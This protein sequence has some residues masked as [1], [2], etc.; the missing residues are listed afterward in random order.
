MS[1]LLHRLGGFAARR[2]LWVIGA[3]VVIAVGLILI[4][5]SAGRPE[6]DNVDLPGTGS[7]NATNLLENKLPQQANGS[8]PIVL[9]S[10]TSLAEGKNAQTVNAVV[11]SLSKN[12]YV[13]QVLS[14][15]SPQGAGAI[16]KDGKIAYVS[17]A[18][19]PS[20]GDITDDQANSVLDAA[21]KP[22]AGTGIAVSAGGYLG[23][24][25]SSPSTR[26]SEI[27][28]VIAALVIM[29][30][31]FRLLVAM[32]LPVT[33]A[34]V[35]LASG[36]AIVGLAGHLF[37]VP[38]IAPTLATMLGLAVGT[39]YSLFIISRHL[40]LLDE[41]AEPNDSIARSISSSGSAVIFAAVMVIIALL[42]LYFSGIPLVRSLGYTTAIVVATAAVAA[43]TL[44][45]AI[46]G[47]L[48]RRIQVLP[49]V[50][51][52]D[53]GTKK[54]S[55]GW[56]G[57]S[58][59]I[60]NHPL[61]SSVAGIAVLV[62][63]AIPALDLYLGAPDYGLLPTDTTE[64]QAYDAITKGFGV[65][66]NGP[67]LI[68]VDV[69][70]KPLTSNPQQVSQLQQ[71]QAQIQ[72]EEAVSGP[73]PQ[74]QSQQQQVSEE[75]QI[76]STPAGD[77]RLVNLEQQISKQDNVQSVSP[78]QTD[79]GGT[80]A[81]FSTTPK[82]SPSDRKTQDLIDHLRDSTIPDTTNGQGMTAYVGGT[83]ASYIDL[84]IKIGDKLL[85]VIAIVVLLSILFLTMAFRTLTIPLVS[86]LINLLAVA[87][88]YGVLT[89]V[90]EKGFGLSL[91]GVDHE[92][93]VVSYVPLMMFAILFGLSMDYQV[94][95]VSRI[96]ERHGGG[97]DN[98]ESVRAG[99]VNAGKPILAAATIMF[100]V[101]FSFVIN[102]NP[103]VKQFGVGLAVSVAIDALVV[104]LIMP[105][106]L[107]LIGERNWF[108]PRWLD[109]I[110]PNLQVE[111]D[112]KM[113]SETPP[114]Q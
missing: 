60:K 102:G 26:A 113:K 55:K 5:N 20:S 77:Q 88:S 92:M 66:T 59:A 114:S 14:P 48:G 1:A 65:G 70:G 56:D 7:Q 39:D 25:L 80:A 32:P 93:P 16:T 105:G 54:Q 40:R 38:S 97:A 79:K 71:Q 73:T 82:T 81:V 34:I 41:G 43:I 83:T 61:I 2:A 108:M 85:L 11:A 96:E 57:W 106:L 101:F 49:L 50:R 68:A 91:L 104:L 36:L 99:L 28:A 24:Q 51:K 107:E 110:L 109:R 75:L 35:A 29:L 10:S 78:A 18:L 72:Q 74:L 6:S 33:T 47:L 42:C 103:I 52:L 84:A 94:F 4:A 3:W 46:L 58:D 62:G 27:I 111:G 64:R 9:Q 45:P 22:A 21:K 23:Q 53:D 89:A 90:F 69:H 13:T 100:A 17:A 19:K 8:N 76:A 12:K 112:P 15:L 30:I 86:A 44:L 98:S 63:I 87:A 31:A 37:D 67:L 95:L